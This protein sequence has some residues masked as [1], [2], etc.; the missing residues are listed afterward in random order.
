MNQ[1]ETKS[2]LTTLNSQLQS[3]SRELSNERARSLQLEKLTEQL[4]ADIALGMK[5]SQEKE[6]SQS[7][8]VD[9]FKQQ[10]TELQLQLQ[11]Q[12]EM[13]QS[14]QEEI[15]FLKEQE[16]TPLP[17]VEAI[18]PRDTEVKIAG[19]PLAL[20]QQQPS[21]SPAPAAISPATEEELLNLQQKLEALGLELQTAIASEESCNQLKN[22]TKNDIKKWMKDF[23][24]ANGTTSSP[25]S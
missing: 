20:L 17:V 4:K 13:V 22:S 23:E 15:K 7:E 11:Q 12:L 10:V 14:Q 8:S 24:K 9:R 19:P 2:Q 1:N 3:L 18:A 6:K 21:Q 16:A 5:E 25:A